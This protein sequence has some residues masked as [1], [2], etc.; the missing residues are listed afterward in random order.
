MNEDIQGYVNRPKRYE[1]IDGTGEMIVGLTLMGFALAGYMETLL[2][3]D[4]SVWMR[5]V[6]IFASL[7]L[8]VS[9]AYETRRAIKGRI[10]WPRTGYV[11]YPRHGRTWWVTTITARLIVLMVAVGLAFLIRSR[12]IYLNWS[13]SP[14][15]WNLRV[16]LLIII[17]VT[18]Y[19]I[20]IPRKGGGHWW[21]W[22]V[23]LLMI[24]G[25][26]TFALIVP[27]D[28]G[29]WARPPVLFIAL[30]WLGSG[31]GTLYSYVHH[32]KPATPETK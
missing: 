18:A 28:F 15:E 5:V 32:T 23:L 24:L 3:E 6:V 21:K 31:A 12:H 25:V 17:S 4:S 7:T 9:L 11:A 8:A 20:W 22:L 30:L 26:I 27:G 14:N 19:A 13:L 16:V 10:T 1:N 29:Q 2:P